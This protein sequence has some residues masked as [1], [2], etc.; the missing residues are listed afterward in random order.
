MKT[1]FCSKTKINSFVLQIN[2]LDSRL[3]IFLLLC[4]NL[5]S[6]SV[7]S[8][9]SAYFPLAKQFIDPAW[10]PGSFS[11]TEW[12]GTRYLFQ[13]IA[14]YALQF[15]SFEQLSF[16]GRIVNFALFAFPLGLIFRELKIK[17]IGILLILQL[18]ALDIGHQYLV[19]QEWIFQGFE[20]KTIAYI[21]IFYSF[22]YVLK[23]RYLWAALFAALASYFHILVGG[24]FFVLLFLY[25]FVKERNVKTL[26]L[27]VVTYLLV[28]LPFIAYLALHLDKSGS[29]INAVDIDYVSVFVRN[30]HHVAP[31]H[32][33]YV[34]SVIP[35]VVVCVILLWTSI[36]YFNK[37]NNEFVRKLSLIGSIS[38]VIVLVGLVIT[39]ID[40]NGRLLKYYLFR[41]SAIGTFSYV[42][43]FALLLRDKYGQKVNLR[44][45][46]F[47][48]FTLLFLYGIGK[49][50]KRQVDYCN[51]MQPV[52]ELT[53]F[54]CQHTPAD[55][56]FL[57]LGKEETLFP[58]KARREILVLYKCDPGGG[59]KIYEWY[60][61]VLD[62]NRLIENIN[63]IDTITQKYKLDY[64][65]DVK[66]I[67]DTRLREVY[68]NS[69]YYLY[70]II[71]SDT[72]RSY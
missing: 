51:D 3:L 33:K 25:I 28:A 24:W 69:Q 8:N 41:I 63:Y 68:R 53:G 55:A 66:K 56:V 15:L 54:A 46:A 39:F 13:L 6:F 57:F 21:F 32:S 38:V 4:L 20:A 52:E 64:L 47:V 23:E 17:N 26:F 11:F 40:V 49:N 1:D 72:L 37:N 70:E 5:L 48:A 35:R 61:R 16:F 43:M 65:I 42:L 18:Y 59:E 34:G 9:E 50:I 60:M 29:V 22:Y 44:A 30:A 27:S 19:G 45:I 7:D 67:E 71:K 58:S 36:V 10:I 62:R 31:L 2:K 14:G 12:V